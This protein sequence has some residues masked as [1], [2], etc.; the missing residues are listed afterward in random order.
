M[1]EHHRYGHK[2]VLELVDAA[3]LVRDHIE[4]WFGDTWDVQGIHFQQKLVILNS[5]LKVFEDPD[6]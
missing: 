1:I 2:N 6:E 3:R 5:T 4:R